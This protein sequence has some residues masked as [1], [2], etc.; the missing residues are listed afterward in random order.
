LPCRPCHKPV[1]RLIHHRCMRE[2]AP[3]AVV[4]A[5]ERA[6][7]AVRPRQDPGSAA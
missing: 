2:I 3:E 5:A 6:I 7:A 1:C 4:A